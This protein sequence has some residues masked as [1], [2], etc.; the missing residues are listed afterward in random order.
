MEKYFILLRCGSTFAVLWVNFC[1]GWVKLTRS[2][3]IKTDFPKV[4]C[5]VS[6]NLIV[7]YCSV[8]YGLVAIEI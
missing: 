5:S 7:F 4:G 1:C 6:A 3:Y 8:T 2:R